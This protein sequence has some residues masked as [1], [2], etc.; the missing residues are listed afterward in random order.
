MAAVAL[1]TVE[2]AF[3]RV[4]F[5]LRPALLNTVVCAYCV[6]MAFAVGGFAVAP[7]NEKRNIMQYSSMYLDVQES[8]AA[9]LWHA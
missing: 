3:C 9:K 7:D 1:E 6:S 5:D 8:A 4:V 2:R